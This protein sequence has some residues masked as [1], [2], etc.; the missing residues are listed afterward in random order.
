MHM[1]LLL[2]LYSLSQHHRVIVASCTACLIAQ[3]TDVY[4][5]F[6]ILYLLRI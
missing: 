2:I 6:W 5:F 4:T 1:H 3:L